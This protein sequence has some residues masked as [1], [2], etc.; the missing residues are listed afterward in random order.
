LSA[1]YCD[2]SALYALLDRSDANA[3][4]AAKVWEV[5]TDEATSLVTTSYVVLE[6]VALVQARLGMEA[7]TA[8]R[9]IVDPFISV[10]YVDAPLHL[11][12]LE[13]VV[14]LSRRA[15][16]LVDCTSFAFMR[17]HG[18]KC[19]FAFDRHFREFGFVPTAE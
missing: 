6:T 4:R 9:M 3:G 7:V 11:A 12:A 13:Q 1:V 8:L 15:L 14:S 5:L 17:Q 18:I 2:T 16:S 10:H 19:V